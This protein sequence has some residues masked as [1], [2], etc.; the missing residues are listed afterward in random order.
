MDPFQAEPEPVTLA[1]GTKF[2]PDGKFEVNRLLGAGGMGQ[3]YLCWDSKMER[4]VAVKVLFDRRAD[5]LTRFQRERRVLSKLDRHHNVV[6]VLEAGDDPLVGPYF[7]MEYLEGDDLKKVVRKNGPLEI[8]WTIE[9]ILSVIRAAGACHDSGAVHRDLKAANI[10]VT[11]DAE[12]RPLVK[13]L[14]FGIAK[15]LASASGNETELT[16]PGLLVGTPE[17][18]APEQINNLGV[19]PATDQYA[20]GVL[21]YFCLVGDLPFKKD[22]RERDKV[23]ESARLL[24]AIVSGTFPRPREVRPSIPEEVEQIILRAM[25]VRPSER[26]PTM[27]A[28]GAALAALPIMRGRRGHASWVEYFLDGEEAPHESAPKSLVTVGSPGG[29]LAN[30]RRGSQGRWR[31]AVFPIAAAALV[32][33]GAGM[34]LRRYRTSTGNAASPETGYAQTEVPA[35]V[36]ALVEPLPMDVSPRIPGAAGE[37]AA[38][39]LAS[40]GAGAAK[41]DGGATTL[42]KASTV[43]SGRKRPRAKAAPQERRTEKPRQDSTPAPTSGPSIDDQRVPLPDW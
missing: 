1:P 34:G 18:M 22:K 28:F 29:T 17:Y 12:K 3:V 24:R 14:D 36:P 11:T 40:A 39:P 8:R 4:H 21:L 5:F 7:V 43:R 35:S 23:K 41:A 30:T 19:T 9:I 16:S 37:V 13:V 15:A 2:G 25:A 6:A 42:E 20:I 26:F 31:R 32:I 38:R 33:A 27:R 10:M